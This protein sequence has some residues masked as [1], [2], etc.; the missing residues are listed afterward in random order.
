MMLILQLHVSIFYYLW[1]G[2]LQQDEDQRVENPCGLGKFGGRKTLD[3]S[4]IYNF[5]WRH[6]ESIVNLIIMTL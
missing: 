3:F 1:W 5:L 4:M 6:A 2:N